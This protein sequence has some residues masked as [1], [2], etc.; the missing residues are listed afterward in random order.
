MIEGALHHLPAIGGK[1]LELLR[2]AGICD[3]HELRCQPPE[4]IGL[5]A[6]KWARVCAEIEQCENAVA[7]DDLNYLLKRFATIDHWRVLERYF[8]R[9]TFFDIETDGLGWESEI[10]VI[11]C[12]QGDEF[13]KFVNGENLEDFL[14]FLEDVELLVSFNGNTFDVPRVE[15]AFNIPDLPCPHLD[16]RWVCYHEGLK[17]GLKRIEQKLGILRPPDL[18]DLDGAEAVR[19]W[20]RWRDVGDERARKLLVKYCGADVAA[21]ELVAAEILKQKGCG[22]TPAACNSLWQGVDELLEAD[23]KRRGSGQ[24]QERSELNGNCETDNK[25][26]AETGREVRLRRYRDKLK[27]TRR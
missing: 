3:W 19:L 17:G 18:L 6:D 25:C 21:L 16:L 23:S 22:I 7:T 13:Y 26:D 12:R 8:T 27:K 4:L 15:R 5:R 9:A 1:R 11:V 24:E 14:Y 20:Y 10:T 2:E